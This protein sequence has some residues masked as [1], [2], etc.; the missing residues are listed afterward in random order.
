MPDNSDVTEVLRSER[1]IEWAAI[2]LGASLL[3]QTGGIIWW[4]G[5]IDQRVSSI[6]KRVTET[7]SQGETIARLD[8][9]TNAMLATIDRIDRALNE[10]SDREARR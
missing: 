3:V 2:A 5:K 6:E 1:R 10:R 4:G 9:R 8:E 7:S